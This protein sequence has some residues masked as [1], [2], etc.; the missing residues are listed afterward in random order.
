MKTKITLLVVFFTVFF[1]GFA[2]VQLD[3]SFG[4]GG[5]VSNAMALNLTYGTDSAIQS[6]GKIVVC[7]SYR[8]A[9]TP[10]IPTNFNAVVARYNIN[11]TIDTS[12]GANGIAIIT[13]QV[14]GSGATSVTIQQD[15][16]IL[17]TTRGHL[18]SF[19]IQNFDVLRLNTNGTLDSSFSMYN[20]I[21]SEGNSDNYPR[22][23]LKLDST[24]KILVCG[25]QNAT[26]V[27]KRF[28]TNGAIDTS[29]GNNGSTYVTIQGNDCASDLAFQ[30]DGKIVVVG[31]AA[32]NNIFYPQYRA[33]FTRLTTNGLLDTTFGINGVSKFIFT[34]QATSV[35][36]VIT[37]D[38]KIILA[39]SIP[40]NSE[41][42]RIGL[43]RADANGNLDTSFGVNGQFL[44]G[45]H[46]SE[47][48]D[49]KIQDG[50]KIVI[51]GFAGPLPWSS[52]AFNG[53][54][55]Y[56]LRCNLDG[57]SDPT[58]S[59]PGYILTSF[60]AGRDLAQS[61][62]IQSD[63]KLVVCG[64]SFPD[65]SA[66]RFASARYMSVPLTTKSFDDN[67]FSVYPNP[68]SDSINLDFDNT[69][70]DILA[71]DLID[72]NGRKIEDLLK[73]SN[74]VKGNNKLHIDLLTLSKGIYFINIT[75]KTNSKIIKIVK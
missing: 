73:N 18:D 63:G 36:L 1:I 51:V 17:V 4:I 72:I 58:F 19:S 35:K 66:Q 15:Q 45:V 8:L 74:I 68:F 20:C 2:Q 21:S 26:F 23:K 6:D 25:R 53:Y 67:K 60:V 52:G 44:V 32:T 22:I 40:V 57:T 50:N 34:G 46:G 69:E 65:Y 56:I 70:N 42:K 71:I 10:G 64:N 39:G 30:S 62:N 43:L 61:I 48:T 3:S 31:P 5:K 55:F 24:G 75:G 14:S 16:K 54:G 37:N 27:I 29:F 12:F 11:G 59:P 41:E 47:F 28:N 33:G 9:G 13:T 49:F 7:G 38:N